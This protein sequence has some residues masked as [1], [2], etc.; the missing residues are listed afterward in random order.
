M[1]LG[2]APIGLES[3]GLAHIGLCP[4]WLYSYPYAD[5]FRESEAPI[6]VRRVNGSLPIVKQQPKK[7]QNILGGGVGG[8]SVS[9]IYGDFSEKCMENLLKKH[10]F[11][12]LLS[13]S[14]NCRTVIF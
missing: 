4:I 5:F 8:K 3:N 12:F 9:N 13:R 10:N 7:N 14:W 1:P 2:L 11:N 6:K